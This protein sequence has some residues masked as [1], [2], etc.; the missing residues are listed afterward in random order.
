MTNNPDKPPVELLEL[1]IR[2]IGETIDEQGL[3]GWF[4]PA[5]AKAS[6][7]AEMA[8]DDGNNARKMVDQ[9]LDKSLR[10]A[11]EGIESAGEDGLSRSRRLKVDCLLSAVR[12]RHENPEAVIH[13][14]SRLVQLVMLKA[15]EALDINVGGPEN[16]AIVVDLLEIQ[17]QWV[18]FR[19]SVDFHWI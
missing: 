4:V 3:E 17:R 16:I 6:L 2:R 15:T 1:S 18:E 19:S 7:L 11:S 13:L 12:N 14:A 10:L 9:L 8:S 5:I